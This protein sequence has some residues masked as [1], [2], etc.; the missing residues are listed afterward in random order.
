M[1]GPL[2]AAVT[3]CK[4]QEGPHLQRGLVLLAGAV[5][6]QSGQLRGGRH[7]GED[8]VGLVVVGHALQDLRA[9]MQAQPH[10]HA[11]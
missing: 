2:S 4:R 3:V 6:V 5:V 11:P 9:H 10:G 8:E 7:D 1:G